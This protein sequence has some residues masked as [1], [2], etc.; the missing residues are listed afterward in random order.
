MLNYQ[1][2]VLPRLQSWHLTLDLVHVTYLLFFD[3][4]RMD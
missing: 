3:A 4:P 1:T 2:L